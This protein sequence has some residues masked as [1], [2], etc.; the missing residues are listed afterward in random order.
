MSKEDKTYQIGLNWTGGKLK[1]KAV[2]DPTKPTSQEVATRV[3]DGEDHERAARREGSF[4]QQYRD[5]LPH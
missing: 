4:S 2:P 5:G 3:R 1:L